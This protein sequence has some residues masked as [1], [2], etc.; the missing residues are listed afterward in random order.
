VYVEQRLGTCV[1]CCRVLALQYHWGLP[2][3]APRGDERTAVRV[4]PCP[5]CRH[6]NPFLIRAQAHGFELKQVPGP[7]PD[8]HVTA[9][10]LRRR[11]WSRLTSRFR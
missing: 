10:P 7:D 3:A 5:A 6:P 8:V 11:L 9:R 1:L 4:F 2:R